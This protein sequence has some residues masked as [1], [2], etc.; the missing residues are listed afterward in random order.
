M[1]KT[2]DLAVPTAEGTLLYKGRKDAQV[3]LRGFRIELEEISGILERN[4]AVKEAHVQVWQNNGE[5]YLVAYYTGTATAAA[6]KQEASSHLP[7]YMH[8]SYYVQLESFPLTVNGKLAA[9]KLPAPELTAMAGD[10]QPEGELEETLAGIWSGV[11]Q[12]DKKRDRS[13]TKL[14]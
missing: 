6:L 10:V 4:S 14:F 13:N 7:E 5:D 3:Q 8:P 12:L 11:L 9:D 2:G 1:Y